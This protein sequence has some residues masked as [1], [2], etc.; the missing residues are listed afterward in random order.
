M[1]SWNSVPRMAAEMTGMR[2]KKRK[3]RLCKLYGKRHGEL[4][5]VDLYEDKEASLV[6]GPSLV[7]RGIESVGPF[8]LD[9][10]FSCETF[11]C[12]NTREFHS[13]FAAAGQ[14]IFV[15]CKE[16][17]CPQDL[18]DFTA[19]QSKIMVFNVGL[20]FVDK[21]NFD[22]GFAVQI[23]AEDRDTQIYLIILFNSG[24]LI[25]YDYSPSSGFTERRIL[26]SED[27]KVIKFFI[28]DDVLLYTDGFRLF[29]VDSSGKTLSPYLEYP[30]IDICIAKTEGTERI[31]I[32]DR[33]G[34]V[35]IA[36]G[37]FR[38][39]ETLHNCQMIERFVFV[40][41]QNAVLL[42]ELL[43]KQFRLNRFCRV[44]PAQR[45][46]LL[47]LTNSDGSITVIR[48][49]FR[50]IRRKTIMR[51]VQSKET[52]IFCTSSKEIKKYENT[53][54]HLCGVHDFGKFF[55]LS[56]ENGLLIK[57]PYK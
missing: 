18:F 27:E 22:Y 44:L 11:Q 4:T 40:Y 47:F 15:G 2:R 45:K 43:G 57:V 24:I 33:N 14:F 51:V 5:N 20:E 35:Y 29:K 37:Q 9:G 12:R 46:E 50:S 34:S 6:S 1:T 21:H 7:S 39:I 48:M 13:A 52:A 31:L 36:D 23:W 8:D 10:T 17:G 38:P 19:G 49:F 54:L 32:L 41:K 28:N 16:N 25:E 56:C 42:V 26:S 30:I 55:V 53:R 3:G